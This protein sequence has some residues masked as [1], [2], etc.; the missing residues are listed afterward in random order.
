MEVNVNNQMVEE[1]RWQV[2]GGTGCSYAAVGEA[3]EA[4]ERELGAGR[5]S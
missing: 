4:T 3:Q 1:T 5:T 2:G